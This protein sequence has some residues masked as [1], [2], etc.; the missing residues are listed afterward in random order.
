MSVLLTH[1]GLPARDHYVYAPGGD[2]GG[3]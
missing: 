3:A 2:T 1:S